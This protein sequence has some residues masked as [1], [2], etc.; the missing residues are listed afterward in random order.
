MTRCL[1]LDRGEEVERV[2]EVRGELEAAGFRAEEVRPSLDPHEGLRLPCCHERGTLE[3][4]RRPA[5]ALR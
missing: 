5:Q 1:L 2:V 3:A 4:D